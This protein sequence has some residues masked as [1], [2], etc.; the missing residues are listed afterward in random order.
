MQ[1]KL[2]LN[3][4]LR[5]TQEHAKFKVLPPKKYKKKKEKKIHLAFL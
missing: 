3:K 2:Q 1:I 4:P 5:M